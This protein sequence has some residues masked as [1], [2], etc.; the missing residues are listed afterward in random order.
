M[1]YVEGEP[2]PQG[3]R[4][5]TRVRRGAVLAGALMAG[6]TYGIN[7]FIAG[8]ENGDNSSDWLYVPVVGGWVYASDVCDGDSCSFLVLHNLTHSAGVVLLIYGLAAR[9]KVLVRN[10]V[11]FSITPAKVGSGSGVVVRGTF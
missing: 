4:V 3:Y 2:I 10:D 6:I 8:F 11:G 5:E 9:R 7:L 1:D